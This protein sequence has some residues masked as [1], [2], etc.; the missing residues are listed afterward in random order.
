LTQIVATP[1][2][3][4]VLSRVRAAYMS[5]GAYDAP[6]LFSIAAADMNDVAVGVL[7]EASGEHTD[8]AIT[9]VASCLRGSACRDKILSDPTFVA[10]VLDDAAAVGSATV[11]MIEDTLLRCAVPRT[12][13]EELRNE[14]E[15]RAATIRDGLPIAARA[16]NLYDRIVNE[17]HRVNLASRE[18]VEVDDDDDDDDA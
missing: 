11:E 5:E 18:P 10:T 9:F 1:E 4:Q 16:R 8:A 17:M 7:L 3:K 6:R 2:Y 14:I 13:T 12:T 15:A